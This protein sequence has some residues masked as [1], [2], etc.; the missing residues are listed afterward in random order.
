MNPSFTQLSAISRA[1]HTD[2]SLRINPK[3]PV[4]DALSALLPIDETVHHD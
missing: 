1:S 2:R 4:L 3:Y